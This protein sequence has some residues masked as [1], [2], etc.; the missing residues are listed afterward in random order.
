MDYLTRY[1]SKFTQIAKFIIQKLKK[2]RKN[3]LLFLFFIFF[4]FFVGNLFGTFVNWV[5]QFN[6][7]DTVLIFILVCLNEVINFIIYRRNQR[8]IFNFQNKLYSF[9][10]AFK[11]GILLGFFVDSFKVGS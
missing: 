10:N 9:L 5:R 1:Y 11:I 3:F 4:G 6:I 2:I 7:A 8:N